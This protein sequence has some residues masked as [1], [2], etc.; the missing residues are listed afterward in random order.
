MDL[1]KLN[2]AFY[3]TQMMN[4]MSAGQI[5]LWHALVRIANKSRW[6]DW[7]S[8]AGITLVQLSGLSL[9][10]VKKARNELK[11]R[12]L[13]DFKPN[14]TKATFYQIAMQESSRNGSQN[15]SRNGSRNGSQNSSQNGSSL[16]KQNKTKQNTIP[17]TPSRGE[18]RFEAF[19][20]AYPRKQG[21][22]AARKVF[23]RLKVDEGL[24]AQML[25]AIDAQKRCA[26]WSTDGG[27]YIPQPTTWLNQGRWEDEVDAQPTG[28]P[29]VPPPVEVWMYD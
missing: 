3:T 15:S 18:E 10:G 24:L 28:A 13:I 20:T 7:F 1:Y 9:A 8:V 23:A 17:P 2:E 12:G 5:A 21:K 27:K 14:G 19:W 6:P 16:N 4:P 11:Q 25:E 22:A 26:Q 29:A